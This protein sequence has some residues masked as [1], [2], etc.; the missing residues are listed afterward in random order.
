[1][2][3][4]GLGTKRLCVNCGARFYDHLQS[5]ITCPKCG[6]VFAVMHAHKRSKAAPEPERQFA[7]PVAQSP[8]PGGS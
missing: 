2:T 8:G 6:T 3:K 7:L 1:M 5:A 4:P